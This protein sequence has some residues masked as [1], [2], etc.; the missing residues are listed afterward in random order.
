MLE[1]SAKHTQ[2]A[3]TADLLRRCGSLRRLEL[4][5]DDLGE[6]TAL[7]LA[8]LPLQRLEHLDLS[9]NPLSD[10][11]LAR[12]LT[13]PTLQHLQVLEALGTG[14]STELCRAVA[15]HS[16]LR[17]L[18]VLNLGDEVSDEAVAQLAR[19]ELPHIQRIQLRGA[20]Q[21]ALEAL[22]RPGVFVTSARYA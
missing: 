7:A 21:Q 18:R 13:N 10:A 12:I 8:E 14:A 5:H 1:L 16:D 4:R 22:A 3:P 19:A 20:S 2:D 9:Y 15:E 6:Q 17:S 11:A